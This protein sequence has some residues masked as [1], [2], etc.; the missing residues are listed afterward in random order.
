M[1]DK[2]PPSSTFSDDRELKSAI[3]TFINAASGAKELTDAALSD[4]RLAQLIRH[5][6]PLLKR[7]CGKHG[8]MLQLAEKFNEISNPCLMLFAAYAVALEREC[9]RLNGL[10]HV[11]GSYGYFLPVCPSDLRRSTLAPCEPSSVQ[12]PS[13]SKWSKQLTP[14]EWVPHIQTATN[15]PAPVPSHSHT[16]D[17]P[18]VYV[19]FF[20]YRPYKTPRSR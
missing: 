20:F 3:V 13:K 14:R 15:S 8:P 10:L 16:P 6:K 17:D 2:S 1:V 19:S 9:D 11:N 5:W 7:W 4:P 18:R 12:K